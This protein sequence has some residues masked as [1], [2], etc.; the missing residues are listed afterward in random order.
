MDYKTLGNTG[1]LVSRLC[2]G[3]MTFGG[4]K[5]ARARVWKTIG[6]VDQKG[7]DELVKAAV[8]SGINFFDTADVY[9]DGESEQTL[10]QS[11]K[12]LNIARKDVV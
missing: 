3:T 1:L 9:S 10:G 5:G 4:A 12:N 11:L 2:L 8:E 7:A 6:A